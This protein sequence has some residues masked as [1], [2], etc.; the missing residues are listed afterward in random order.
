MRISLPGIKSIGYLYTSQL[1]SHIL[2]KHLAGVPVGV[3]AQP[4]PVS[5]VNA[6]CEAEQ[7]PDHSSVLEKTTLEFSTSDEFPFH[8]P[9][10]FVITDTNNRSYVIGQKEAPAPQ[11]T[12]NTT[13]N[14]E[15]NIHLVKVV[16][17]ARKSLV[18]CII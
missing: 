12:V 3:Y 1:P 2:Q 10:A 4:T 9:L 17:S 13:I 18:T 6:S 8:L 7:D 5:F 16:F 15:K 14:D 11:I